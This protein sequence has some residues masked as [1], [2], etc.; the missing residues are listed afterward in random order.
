[1][2]PPECPGSGQSGI[3]KD[4]HNF[5]ANAE[6]IAIEARTDAGKTLDKTE[7]LQKVHVDIIRL[8]VE[9]EHI[10]GFQICPRAWSEVLKEDFRQYRRYL[11]GDELSNIFWSTSNIRNQSDLSNF[12]TQLAASWHHLSSLRGNT[13]LDVQFDNTGDEPTTPDWVHEARESDSDTVVP[14]T[15]QGDLPYTAAPKPEIVD[16]P[17]TLDWIQEA[18]EAVLKTIWR[19][20]VSK[21]QHVAQSLPVRIGLKAYRALQSGLRCSVSMSFG[22]AETE[23]WQEA[24]FRVTKS[25]S[26]FVLCVNGGA[27]IDDINENDYVTCLICE[28]KEAHSLEDHLQFAVTCS[29][30]SRLFRL[31][32]TPCEGQWVDLRSLEDII[33]GSYPIKSRAKRLLATRLSYALL[34]FFNAKWLVPSWT[35]S[36]IVFPIIKKHVPGTETRLH[37]SPYIQLQTVALPD[38]IS[39]QEIATSNTAGSIMEPTSRLY[40]PFPFLVVLAIQL[41]EIYEKAPLRD[42]ANKYEVRWLARSD[43][44]G[45]FRNAKAVCEKMINSGELSDVD[46]ILFKAIQSCLEAPDWKKLKDGFA[47]RTAIDTR[48]VQYVE[49]HLV[50]SHRNVELMQLDDTSDTI[51]VPPEETRT[52]PTVVVPSIRL[53]GAAQLGSREMFDNIQTSNT[54]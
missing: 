25:A 41:M 37:L 35:S 6:Q 19:A 44:I 46:E 11:R 33:S 43:E 39:G 4:W 31:K 22:G 28:C 1:M 8:Q 14:S 9:I 27:D 17:T 54:K 47:V 34:H 12:S 38:I 16:N 2:Q 15:A 48:I 52:N 50:K 29:A 21:C 51:P 10:E 7:L 20:H 5:L 30:E 49:K 42:I 53:S 36:N 3:L 40:H 18:H 13:T 32:Y 24:D 23:F 26:R 45:L